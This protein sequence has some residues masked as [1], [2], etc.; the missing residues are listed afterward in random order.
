M[1][2]LLLADV[3]E[4]AGLVW[5]DLKWVAQDDLEGESPEA[6]TRAR[7]LTREYNLTSR[8]VLSESET[9]VEGDYWS[10]GGG[11]DEV[12]LEVR[13]AKRIGVEIGDTLRFD[14]QGRPMDA[15]ITSLRRINWLSLMP[16]FFVVFPRKRLE[17]APQTLVGSVRLPAAETVGFKD[18]L[19]SHHPNISLIDLP[20]IFDQVRGLFHTL[21]VT[22][23]TLALLCALVGLM[24]L[25]ATLQLGRPERIERGNVLRTLGLDTAGILRVEL[26]EVTTIG[27]ISGGV[28]LLLSLSLIHVIIGVIII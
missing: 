5:G 28:I 10:P 20:P 22:V 27:A 19:F 16:N 23:R 17:D 21:G 11:G 13:F 24:I 4:A 7:F 3:L 12:S 15:R 14:V 26:V 25:F 1:P 9:L 8:D 6:R 2:L 18:A